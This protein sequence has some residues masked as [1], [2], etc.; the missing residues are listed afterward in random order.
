MTFDERLADHEEIIVKAVWDAVPPFALP[1]CE[2]AVCVCRACC[3]TFISILQRITQAF[4]WL[5]V[6][7]DTAVQ[8]L[9]EDP[10]IV[11]TFLIR[12]A[13]HF[14]VLLCPRSDG[15]CT[16]Y[17]YRPT[18]FVQYTNAETELT[19]EEC[20]QEARWSGYGG[21]SGDPRTSSCSLSRVQ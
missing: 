18:F 12:V 1:G 17:L 4:V 14:Q 8:Q 21:V 20:R 19:S 11:H 7:L 16:T 9:S 13:C 15:I 5:T 10:C 3:R 2:N 6:A